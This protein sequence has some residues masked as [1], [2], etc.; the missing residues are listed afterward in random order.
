L[1]HGGKIVFFGRFVAALRVAAASLAGANRFPWSRFLLFNI[2][3]GI[4][5][6]T[7]Y[8]TAAHLFGLHVHQLLGSVSVIAV[9]LTAVLIAGGLVLFR[10]YEARLQRAAE[11]ALPGSLSEN[12]SRPNRL[13]RRQA[14]LS[15]PGS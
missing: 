6:V 1:L 12:R 13:D 15:V 10:R 11:R 5:W 7:L 9:A 3:G 14:A 2:A 4:I 8:G